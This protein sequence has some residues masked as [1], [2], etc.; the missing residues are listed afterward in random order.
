MLVFSICSTL[1]HGT[2]P[3]DPQTP[4]LFSKPFA[5]KVIPCPGVKQVISPTSEPKTQKQSNALKN[6][7]SSGWYAYSGSPSMDRNPKEQAAKNTKAKANFL[8]L[9]GINSSSSASD[10]FFIAPNGNHFGK[11]HK[12]KS[13][14]LECLFFKRPEIVFQA[15]LSRLN[16]LNF[17]KKEQFPKK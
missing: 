6:N 3:V 4:A 9:I 16:H 15:T 7:L 14:F 5:P 8:L 2:S 13:V 10:F 17:R 11:P 12:P 1:C